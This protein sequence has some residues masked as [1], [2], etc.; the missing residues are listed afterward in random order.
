M[1]EPVTGNELSVYCSKWGED[2]DP[3]ETQ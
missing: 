2:T 3:A 1:E